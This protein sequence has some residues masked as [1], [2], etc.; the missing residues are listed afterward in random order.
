MKK[1]VVLLVIIAIA[2]YVT[3]I[4]AVFG[5]INFEEESVPGTLISGILFLLYGVTFSIFAFAFYYVK[6]MIKKSQKKE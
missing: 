1:S 6:K 3:G 5:I 4:L 2:C